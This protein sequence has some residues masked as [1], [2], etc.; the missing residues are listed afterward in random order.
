MFFNGFKTE[1]EEDVV[2]PQIFLMQKQIIITRKVDENLL[3]GIV[4]SHSMLTE[5]FNTTEYF[6]LAIFQ[7]FCNL[8]INL[9]FMFYGSFKEQMKDTPSRVEFTENF[10]LFIESFFRP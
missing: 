5:N 1:Q 10:T 7:K 3:L 9:Y 4:V 2:E 8:F 6:N